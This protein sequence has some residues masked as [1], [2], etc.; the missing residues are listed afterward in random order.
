MANV[1]HVLIRD[2]EGKLLAPSKK[3]LKGARV[4]LD[5]KTGTR[6]GDPD[7]VL[8][9][10]RK[11]LSR[12]VTIPEKSPFVILRTPTRPGTG[13]VAYCHCACSKTNDCGGG[14]GGS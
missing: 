5:L 6:T 7:T 9:A 2:K 12:G 1:F 8:S 10:F 14:G 13:P 4:E 3:Y 11:A